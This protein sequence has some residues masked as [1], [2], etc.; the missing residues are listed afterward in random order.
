MK[1]FPLFLKLALILVCTTQ[2]SGAQFFYDFPQVFESV[3][4]QKFNISA[5][6]V[7]LLYTYAAMPNLF[8]NIFA[9]ILV[10]KIGL[11]A[12]LPIF[13]TLLFIGVCLIYL[14][15]STSN[16]TLL[17]AGRMFVGMSFDVTAVGQLLAVEKWF[18]GSSLTF[19]LGVANCISYC[20]QSL[21]AYLLP[22]IYLKTRNLDNPVMLV[23]A[24][25]AITFASAT[26]YFLIDR[27]YSGMLK[28]VKNQ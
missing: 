11:G 8:I 23:G 10:A 15:V 22:R 9:S 28:E 27:K 5:S 18:S 25:S 21:A 17:L 3:L 24:F 26:I 16:Y 19:V 14:A 6:K 20:S 4:I 2:W 13:Q 12:S 7:G 1:K